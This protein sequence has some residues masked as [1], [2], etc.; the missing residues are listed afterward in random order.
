MTLDD[1]KNN[2]FLIKRISTFVLNGNVSHAYIFEGA[3]GI[4]K[5]LL[6]D[7]FAKAILCR[8]RPGVGCDSCIVCR[9]INHGNH[10]DVIHIEKDDNSVKD[11]AIEDLQAKLK[12]KPYAGDR[13]IAIIKDADT[14]TRRAQNRLLKTLEEPFPGTVIVLLVE[15][16][17]SLLETILSRCIIMK[18]R[19][20]VPERPGRL[21]ADAEDMVKML[22]NGTP[23]YACKA[24]IKSLSESRDD[25]LDLLDAME[26][27]YGRHISERSVDK[28]ALARAVRNLEDA[29]RKL[30]LGMNVSY[31]LS[32][33]ILEMEDRQW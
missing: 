28:T 10:E 16:T 8:A 26:N 31:A 30:R 11:E 29:R 1:V 2:G 4:D 12:M 20:F 13:S 27:S 22:L 33:M 15:N 25:A 32:N 18:W 21:Q 23:F 3:L 9:K 17:E 5:S 14:M 19:Q 6:A 24:K 7:C